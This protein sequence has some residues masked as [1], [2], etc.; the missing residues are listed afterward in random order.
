M[1]RNLLV[2]LLLLLPGC[3]AHQYKEGL[4]VPIRDTDGSTCRA[5]V[6]GKDIVVTLG[7]CI[8]DDT[9]YIKHD[10]RWYTGTV[11]QRYKGRR[12][13]IIVLRVEGA[14][15]PEFEWFML[16]PGGFPE[17]TITK[18]TGK[19]RWFDAVSYPG[20]SGSPVLDEHGRLVGL[21][22]GHMTDGTDRALLENLPKSMANDSRWPLPSHTC[23][24]PC[25]Q[26]D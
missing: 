19:Q 14:A 24:S 6:I 10:G 20:D 5:A 9:L 4:I 12:D 15:W 13:T 11:I 22:W 2:F 21:V 25:G 7:H 18:H 17:T 16:N 1:L 8:E 23:M 26:T 3:V